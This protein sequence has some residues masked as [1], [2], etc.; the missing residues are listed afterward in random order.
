MAK[1]I[2][3][4]YIQEV[5][6]YMA[7]CRLLNLTAR[8]INGRQVTL[9]LPYRDEL[10]GNPL[11]GVI[12]GGAITTLLDTNCGISLMAATGKLLIAPTL[13]LRID[14]MTSAKPRQPIFSRAEVFRQSK[15]VMFCRGIAYQDD[16]SKP[17]AHCVATFM[18]LD[19]DPL[20]SHQKAE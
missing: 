9:E 19:I 15:H 2:T 8:E 13:D 6:D 11:N 5:L 20:D 17:I 12:H 3:T 7:H 4:D 18:R 16:D 14:Y 10:I 1:P